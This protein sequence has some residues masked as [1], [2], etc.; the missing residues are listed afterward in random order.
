MASVFDST[1][2]L[3]NK[4]RA[5]ASNTKKYFTDPTF[6][7][8]NNFWGS[9]P[10]QTY[11]NTN[12]AQFIQGTGEGLNKVFT[13]YAKLIGE[14]GYQLGRKVIDPK[15]QNQKLP[16]TL[17]LKPE[18]VSRPNIVGTSAAATSKAILGTVGVSNPLNLGVTA[19]LSGGLGY[20]LSRLAGS[21]KQLASREAGRAVGYS[22]I[23][24]GIGKLTGGPQ[25][26]LA[27]T[28][29]GGSEKLLSNIAVKG[30]TS[31]G[32]NLLENAVFTPLTELRQSTKNENIVALLT[33]V[34]GSAVSEVSGSIFKNVSGRLAKL[35][36]EWTPVQA[37][38]GAKQYI[39]DKIGRFAKQ[40]LALKGK[41]P[42]EVKMGKK[43][44][45]QVSE[46]KFIDTERLPQY[47]AEL[48]KEFGV[49]RDF[50]IKRIPLGFSVRKLSLEEH[51]LN[52]AKQKNV[53]KA[54]LSVPKELESLAQEARKYKSAEEFVRGRYDATPITNTPESIKWFSKLKEDIKGLERTNLL[55]SVP[56]GKDGKYTVNPEVIIKKKLGEF[57]SR[58]G[59]N[60]TKDDW[61]GGKIGDIR[62]DIQIKDIKRRLTD[63]YNQSTKGVESMPV[64]TPVKTSGFV[65]TAI[66][67]TQKIKGLQTELQTATKEAVK[68]GQPSNISISE[69]PN[70]QKEIISTVKGTPKTKVNLLDYLRTPDRVLTKIGLGEEA[71]LLKQKYRDYVLDLPKELDKVTAWYKQ[72][73]ESSQNIF[74]YLDGQEI[75]LNPKE[76][77]IANEI[78][79]YLSEWADKLKLPKDKR[80]ASYITHLFEED[81][82]SKEFD[83][84]LAKLISDKIPGSVYDP[85]LQKRLG[86]LGYKED[87]WEAL[88]AY[89]KRA[90]RKYHMDQALGPLKQ[91]S[92]KL[93]LESTNYIKRLADRANLRPTEVDN[94][95]DNFVKSVAGYRFGVRPVANLTKSVRRVIYRGTLGLNIGSAT[96]NLTQGANT[97]AKLGEKYTVKGYFKM[98]SDLASRGDELKRV[99]VL[100]DNIIQDRYLNA[101]KKFWEKFDKVLFSFFS[102]AERVNRGAAYFGAKA[103]ALDQGLSE[104]EAIRAGIKM[105]ED[106]QFVFGSVDTPV[107]LQSDL[108]KMLTQFQSY[109]IK[110]AEFL[111]EMIKNKE[112][113][114]LLRF[115]GASVFMFLTVGKLF[116]MEPKDIV[117]FLSNITEGR[118]A[119]PSIQAAQGL[120]QIAFG[121]EEKRE[122]GVEKLKK[123]F[124][125]FVPAGVQI[126]KS[127]EG[128]KA[129]KEGASYTATGRKRFD[130][131]QTPQNLLRSTLYGQYSLPAA[132]KYFDNLGKSKSSTVAEELTKLKTPEEKKQLW[133]KMVEEKRITKDN[134]SDI[135]KAL[136]D[137]DMKATKQEKSTRSL[138]VKDGSRSR[139]IKQQLDKQKDSNSKK[140]LWKRYVELGIITEEVA[141]QLKELLKNGQK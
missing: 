112:F 124:P 73:P 64:N 118:F 131:E 45:T 99:G 125:A 25:N 98:L 109:N 71:K 40:M 76:L 66:Q 2:Q 5:T 140:E 87:V 82:I 119:T 49:P 53:T 127:I 133:Q 19:L 78:K 84:D 48:D 136:K 104:E 38:E 122:E 31:G 94:L 126:K 47:Y 80:I 12:T 116:G 117:P 79:S 135:K 102:G 57:N 13:P 15:F 114:G 18:Q 108:V 83:Q 75:S 91:A 43:G 50:D 105:V 123:V 55:N 23:Y 34:F 120:G 6:N 130:V 61:I 67:S 62:N 89:V 36:P 128:L 139:I 110:Q 107:A 26:V 106:T 90:T 138:P 63:F 35:H 93:D 59:T 65:D 85:F 95:L 97:Y 69:M 134:V 129:Y 51:R 24:S 33:G 70:A 41:Y 32:V 46:N 121:D 14:A 101:T 10:I 30:L 44:L 17:F 86:K 58:Y 68:T 111:G 92:Q 7:N 21:N 115:S 81:F 74:K 52:A 16:T 27:K 141:I 54:G 88:D 56:I 9:K 11:A 137:I 4:F 3:L 22:P 60:L 100:S 132:Q 72:S 77:Q 113:G 103:K 96:R 20:G 42:S 28:L 39:R 8:G 1:R 29:L 37:T